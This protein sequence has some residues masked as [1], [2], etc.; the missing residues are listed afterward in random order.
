[1]N[2]LIIDIETIPA[3]NCAE[4]ME[5]HPKSKK[6]GGI[7]SILSQC[8]CVGLLEMGEPQLAIEY[9]TGSHQSALQRAVE[10]EY[11]DKETI[12]Q[13]TDEKKLLQSLY[14]FLQKRGAPLRLQFIGFNSNMFDFP[15]LRNRGMITGVPLGQ[16]LPR[17]T[18]YPAANHCDLF[19]QLGGKWQGDV[20]SCSLDDLLWAIT[21]KGKDTNGEQVAKWHQEGNFQAIQDHCREDIRGTALLYRRM[22]GNYFA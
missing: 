4:Y 10:G 11:N 16:V 8:V 1:M 15:F 20:S 14:N 7:H 2:N 13:D 12:L 18:K 6:K 22:K 19:L 5:K 3:P 9:G 21:G 17:E